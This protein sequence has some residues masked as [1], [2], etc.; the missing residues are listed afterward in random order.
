MSATRDLSSVFD[1]E[2]IDDC[3][4]GAV[5]KATCSKRKS[6][7]D[8]TTVI[9]GL[10]V[11]LEDSGSDWL[12]EEE[13]ETPVAKKKKAAATANKT[14]DGKKSKCGPAKKSSKPEKYDG[15][16]VFQHRRVLVN[17][18]DENIEVAGGSHG[19]HC[20]ALCS[21]TLDI[22]IEAF[23][24]LLVPSVLVTP[25][26]FDESTAAVLVE[27]RSRQQAAAVLGRAAPGAG[28]RRL[29]RLDMVFL[30]ARGQL[31]LWWTMT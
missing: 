6:P 26:H 22:T 2:D 12:P 18:V 31:R 29:N 25:E 30:P 17:L 20:K 14:T 9:Q 24:A 19:R 13:D 8:K 1:D 4:Q 21:L 28:G 15:L 11:Q 7:R 10:Q 16:T 27:A 3:Q 5:S 23:R